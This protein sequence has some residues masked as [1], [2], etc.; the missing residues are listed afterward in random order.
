MLTMAPT[1]T[2]DRKDLATLELLSER[3]QL[4]EK[5]GLSTKK[6]PPSSEDADKVEK[7]LAEELERLSIM[8]KEQKVFALHGIAHDQKDPE[9]I[10][11]LLGLLEVEIR[12]IPVK[13]AYEQAKYLNEAYVMGR[14]FRLS[15]LRCDNFD[16]KLAS[17]RIV[18]HF[19]V[20][21]TWFG[22]GPLLARD[23]R[24]SDLNEETLVA[25]KAATHQLL[26]VR[27][28][29]GRLVVFNAL[30]LRPPSISDQA[31]VGSFK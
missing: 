27:D 14:D 2:A 4:A 13:P 12:R 7:L 30:F 24:I 10:D 25:L 16:T 3:D 8:E 20:K 1:A 6:F 5:M 11:A 23:I 22:D 19:E 29:A 17:Q 18:K 28:V 15:F 9:D 31:L 26:P 21:K